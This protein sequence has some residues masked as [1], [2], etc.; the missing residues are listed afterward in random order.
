[1]ELNLSSRGHTSLIPFSSHSPF[2]EDGFFDCDF[3][4]YCREKYYTES[5]SHQGW[6]QNIIRGN[7]RFLHIFLK[8]MQRNFEPVAI[9]VLSPP[10]LQNGKAMAY[11]YSIPVIIKCFLLPISACDRPGS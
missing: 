9:F 10:V 5:Y 8:E 3:E 1:M 11:W 6:N 4:I 2:K 7:E